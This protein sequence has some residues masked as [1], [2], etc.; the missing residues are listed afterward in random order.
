MLPK[1]DG[2]QFTLVNDAGAAGAVRFTLADWVPLS[3]AETVAVWLTLIA[4]EVTVNDALLAPLPMATL[5][6]VDNCA[7]SSE[8]VTV[9]VPV[10]TLSSV[11]VQVAL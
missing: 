5:A 6:G 2:A 4:V 11:T 9:E 1:V 3:D 8:R 7:L 10:D